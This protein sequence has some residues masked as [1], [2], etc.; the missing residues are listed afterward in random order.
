MEY[1]WILRC[2]AV[3]KQTIRHCLPCRRMLQDISIP[4]MV[5]LPAERLP[6]KNWFV[7]ETTGLD[8]IGP[9]PVKNHGRLSSRYILLFTCLVV[10][11]V[12]LEVWNDLTT[13]SLRGNSNCFEK[14]LKIENL[15][16]N[17]AIQ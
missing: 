12:H 3:V 4:Q 16:T 14:I 1:Y 15:N 17:L 8:F 13:A 10:R 6:K 9:F 5:D 11:A 7:F 2:R